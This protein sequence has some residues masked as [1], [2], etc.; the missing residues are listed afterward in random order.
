[1]TKFI[2]R[3]EAIT[4][5]LAAC[6]RAF[7]QAGVPWVIVGGIV[8]GYA[9]YKEIMPWDTDLDIVVFT[10]LT[11]EN[12]QRLWKALCSNGFNFPKERVDF[13]Y[14]YRGV[15]CNLELYHRDGEFYNCLPKSTPGLKFVE[16]AKWFDSVQL[17]DFLGDKYPMPNNVE[18][19]VSDHY[20]SDWKTNIIKNHEQ[21]FTDKRGGRDQS[22]W[23]TSRASKCGDLWPK[24]LK[25]GDSMEEDSEL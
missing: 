15:E 23:T 1:M 17:V 24:A 6:K 3:R 18:E 20:G 13:M 11:D 22:T 12:W 10:E 7:N 4:A 5:D 2:D 21:Y 9:R 25:I 14:C 19:F 8:L 16:R